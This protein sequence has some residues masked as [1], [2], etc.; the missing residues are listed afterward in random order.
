M[1]A[2][3]K[4]RLQQMN[5]KPMQHVDQSHPLADEFWLEMRD[6]YYA[7]FRLPKA[8]PKKAASRTFC[9]RVE[10]QPDL[11]PLKAMLNWAIEKWWSSPVCPG[12]DADVKVTLK[13]N[14]LNRNELRWLFARV[15]DCHVAV[16]TVELEANYTDERSFQ[17]EELEFEIPGAKALRR[18][19]AGLTEYCMSLKCAKE[20]S[21]SAASELMT[22]L[23]ATAID[24]KPMEQKKHGAA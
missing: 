20:R 11:Y 21:A 18:S 17:D 22:A 6:E 7:T 5:K 2:R 15:V 8:T 16:E 23:R 12:G 19:L 1:T 4:A 10:F 9:F 13:A 14:T 3:P 24:S